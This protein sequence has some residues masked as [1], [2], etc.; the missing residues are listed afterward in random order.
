MVSEWRS[1]IAVSLK[2]GGGVHLLKPAKLYT[3]MLNTT[4]MTRTDAQRRVCAAL[5]PYRR[6]TRGTSLRELEYTHTN[7]FFLSKRPGY[8]HPVSSEL[9]NSGIRVAVGD[10]SVTECQQ[11]HSLYQT[12]KTVHVHTKY[13]TC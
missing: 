5:V 12:N 8:R 11:W 10:Y 13:N 7:D 1:V 2:V 4:Y 9:E 6:A 3:C